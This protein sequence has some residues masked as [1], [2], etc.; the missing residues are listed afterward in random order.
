[1]EAAEANFIPVKL[2]AP[3][4]IYHELLNSYNTKQLSKE[5]NTYIFPLFCY[6][7][8]HIYFLSATLSQKVKY[9]FSI[10]QNN[11]PNKQ[12]CGSLKMHIRELTIAIRKKKSKKEFAGNQRLH[13]YNITDIFCAKLVSLA[14]MSRQI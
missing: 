2:I 11:I 14:L 9:V 12:W 7:N 6:L 10:Q 8:M 1:M 13:Y 4:C 3:W 5:K